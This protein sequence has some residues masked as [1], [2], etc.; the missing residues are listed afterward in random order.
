MVIKPMSTYLEN[1]VTKVAAIIEKVE[2]NIVY[3]NV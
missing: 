1:K 3:N 2:V